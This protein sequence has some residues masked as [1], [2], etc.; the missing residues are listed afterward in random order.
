MDDIRVRFGQ[1]IRKRRHKLGVSQEEFADICRLH[2]TYVGGIERGERNVAVVNIERIAKAFRV[3]MTKLFEG[4]LSHRNRNPGATSR[5]SWNLLPD[6][7]DDDL[8]AWRSR[9]SVTASTQRHPA[10]R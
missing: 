6:R 8:L 10:W 9:E 3:P 4:S 7:I 5:F 1:A 2:R